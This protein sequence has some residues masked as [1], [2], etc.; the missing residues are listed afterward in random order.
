LPISEYTNDK[1]ITK[2]TRIFAQK[3]A[4]S[5][6]EIQPVVNNIVDIV[7]LLEILG[8]IENHCKIRI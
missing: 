7:G 2:E 3:V 6:I 8:Y 1:I 4:R 5:I